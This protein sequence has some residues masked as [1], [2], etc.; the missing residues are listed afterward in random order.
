MNLPRSNQTETT[1]S[2][3]PNAEMEPFSV[4]RAKAIHTNDQDLPNR[5]SGET[6]IAKDGFVLNQQDSGHVSLDGSP[7]NPNGQHD[8]FPAEIALCQRKLLLHRT[9]TKLKPYEKKISPEYSKRFADLRELLGPSLSQH[10]TCSLK[11]SHH[12]PIAMNLRVLGTDE[13]SAKPWIVILCAPRIA[14]MVRRFFSEAW[15][16]SE[17]HPGNARPDVPCLQ[18]I[19]HAHAP[20]LAAGFINA[21][22]FMNLSP[23]DSSAETLCGSI[24]KVQSQLATIGGLVE[25]KYSHGQREFYGL[26]VGHILTAIS[27]SDAQSDITNVAVDEE[28][29]ADDEDAMADD[30]E[31]YDLDIGQDQ[32][33][34]G[35]ISLEDPHFQIEHANGSSWPHIGKLVKF[36]KQSILN[37]WALVSLP[38][39]RLKPN[40]F[41]NR[42]GSGVYM[43]SDDEPE[44]HSMKSPELPAIL[45]SGLRGSI[46]GTLTHSTSS[47][48]IASGDQFANTYTMRLARRS[49]ELG[50]P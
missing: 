28:V 25:I 11:H 3:M 26:T 15:V 36:R 47:L 33:E 20:I 34:Y 35:D 2:Q 50:S 39:D 41:K 10:L 19:V 13:A 38:M 22:A 18:V 44:I 5:D 31:L 1:E 40:T 46:Y 49:G 8:K 6:R 4:T 16:K 17:C 42:H 37:D 30:E 45:V 32:L 12:G 48:L 23:S 9:T 29:V 21:D 27:D 14:K 43:W 24:I 7:R